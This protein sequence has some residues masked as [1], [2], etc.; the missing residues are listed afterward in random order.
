[1]SV[2]KEVEMKS[3]FDARGMMIICA[4]AGCL[5]GFGIDTWLQKNPQK[6]DETAKDN[7]LLREE[8]D[9]VFFDEEISGEF[10]V[11]TQRMTP[12]PSVE[13]SQAVPSPTTRQETEISFTAIP[14]PEVLQTDAGITPVP[15]T[16]A[17]TQ[18][19]IP[20]TIT[21]TPAMELITPTKAPAV[22]IPQLTPAVPTE[23]PVIT[24]IQKGQEVFTYPTEIFGQTPVV[25]RSDEYV[26]YFEFAMD[27]IESVEEEIQQKNLNEVTLFT[28]FMLKAL[29][30]GIDIQSLKINDPIP[31]AQA[32]LALH[33]AA[34]VM[35][36]KGTGTTAWSAGKYVMDIGGC[37]LN[38]KKAVAYMYEQGIESG[39]RVSGQY[40]YPENSLKEAEAAV[41]FARVRESWN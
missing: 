6:Q 29:F 40:F 19:T 11:P 9:G 20:V 17:P 1:M 28:K 24:P 21:P 18:T 27:L 22:E 4:V 30:C 35:G 12:V 16:T 33:L 13:P 37:S 14:T 10:P 5:A 41:W 38:E 36:K 15:V 39:Y 32:A 8:Y 25:N 7:T 2:R 31:R 26:T 23:T 34:E 3:G